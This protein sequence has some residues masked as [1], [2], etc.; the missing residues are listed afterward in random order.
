MKKNVCT[1]PCHFFFDRFQFHN[2]LHFYISTNQQF[3]DVVFELVF[4]AYALFVPNKFSQMLRNTEYT[5]PPHTHTQMTA[6]HIFRQ[7]AFASEFAASIIYLNVDRLFFL[8]SFHKWA[9]VWC[10]FYFCDL[11][12]T[13][14][15]RLTTLHC[16]G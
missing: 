4:V 14:I 13:R 1:N 9:E 12:R 6:L 5:Q 7:R 16:V 3:C 11:T 10:L 8:V 15:M 2:I